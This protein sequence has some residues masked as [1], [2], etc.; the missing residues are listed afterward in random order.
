MTRPNAP[1]RN[2]AKEV[3]E[4]R[5]PDRVEEVLAVDAAV[6]DGSIDHTR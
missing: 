2:Q 3:G 1:D 4:A 6:V 5:E